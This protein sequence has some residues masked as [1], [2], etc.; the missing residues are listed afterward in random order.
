M[1]EIEFKGIKYPAFQ[2]EGN[3]AQF[4]IPYAK[5]FCKGLGYDIGCKKREWSFPGSFPIDLE[6]PDIWTA[7]NLPYKEVDYIFS[8]HCL[9]HI[10]DWIFTMDYWHQT[11][12]KG[13]ILFLYLPH[14]SQEYWRPW[15]N[16]K[17]KHILT[18]QIIT[19]YMWDKG[20][21]VYS[22]SGYDLNNSFMVVGEKG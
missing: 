19:D 7:T 11:L 2:A 14:Y 13:G 6:F 15:N 3:A 8:S 10:D 21:Y 12:R 20:Y 9:E 16:R 22:Q 4:A 5:K 1:E 18:E 17:H